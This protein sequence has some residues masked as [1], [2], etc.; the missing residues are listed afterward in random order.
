MGTWKRYRGNCRE[1]K[2]RW[3]YYGHEH[4]ESS[5]VDA[6]VNCDDNS[7]PGM[8]TKE[9]GQKHSTNIFIE[10]AVPV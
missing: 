4:N 8:I 9:T 1:L 2:G 5:G 3:R 7:V 6:S 10:F